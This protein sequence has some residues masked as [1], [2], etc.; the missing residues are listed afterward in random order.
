LAGESD[1]TA[2]QKFLISVDDLAGLLGKFVIENDAVL[3]ALIE[4]DEE[5]D[6]SSSVE[7]E[8]NEMVV[9]AKVLASNFNRPIE[10]SRGGLNSEAGGVSV[11]PSS[12]VKS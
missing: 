8:A 9:S 5:Q 10:D 6:F 3:D 4:L 2:R 1:L 11:I 7:I 12:P